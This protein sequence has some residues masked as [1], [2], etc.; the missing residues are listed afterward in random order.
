MRIKCLQEIFNDERYKDYYIT[1]EGYVYSSKVYKEGYGKKV[2]LSKNIQ[3]GY[4]Y[5]NFTIGGDKKRHKR[6]TIHRLVALAFI[7]NP[8]NFKIINHIDEN[9]SNN[10]YSNLEWC[11]SSHNSQHSFNLHP[12]RMEHIR[13]LSKDDV[14]FVLKNYDCNNP[15]F[16]GVALGK[17]FG[18]TRNVIYNIIKGKT[19]KNL[20]K[21]PRK[22]NYKH[23][24]LTDDDVIFIRTYCKYGDSDLGYRGLS[25][26]FKVDKET[27]RQICKN[28]TWNHLPSFE[29]LN[30]N[31]LSSKNTRDFSQEQTISSPD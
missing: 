17:K 12:D 11:T 25:R 13:S 16:S 15:E 28:I 8:N 22:I 23:S 19:Y 7:S 5:F 9:P 3:N 27:I 4:A 21:T 29:E 1:D 6:H 31:Y 24:S 14:E 20:V 10:H 18:V 30:I 2:N 26:K